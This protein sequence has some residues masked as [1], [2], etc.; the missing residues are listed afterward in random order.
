VLITRAVKDGDP[1]RRRLEELGA[2][3]LQLPTITVEPPADWSEI[4]A[5]LSRLA[6]YG[7]VVFTSRHAVD[8]VFGRLPALGLGNRLPPGAEI[9]ASGEVTAGRLHELGVAR[10]MR[11][12]V[13]SGSGVAAALRVY[14]LRGKRILYPT[15]DLARPALREDLE[16]EGAQVDQVVAYRT[17][18]PADRDEGILDA[19]KRGE[20]DVVTLAS[21]SALQNLVAMLRPDEACLRRTH[22]VCIGETTAQAV[23]EEGFEV[24]AVAR[25]P[26][27]EGMVEAICGEGTSGVLLMAYGTPGSLDDVEAYYTHIRGGRTPAPELVEELRERYRLVGGSTPLYAISEATRAALEKRLNA[28][29]AGRYRVILG[30]KHWHPFIEEA[31]QQ[32]AGEGIERAVGLVLAPHYSRMSG[33]TYFE[34][35]EAAQK[36]HGTDIEVRRIESW[37]LHP[38]Y[39]K[40]VADRVRTRLA[41]FLCGSEVTVIFTAHSLP[42]KILEDDDPYPRQLRETSEA[43]AAMLGLERWTFAYQSAGRTSE[44]WLGP[45]LVDA[46]HALA[47]EGVRHILVATIGFV[48]DHLEILYDIDHEAQQA[49]RE[50]GITLKRTESLNANDDFIEGLAELV[51]GSG[52]G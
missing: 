25:E 34:Y 29:E 12:G 36:K 2:A 39:L 22:L 1:L 45:D 17:V 48:S 7:Y 27:A 19:L 23:R 4:D 20:I 33:E 14:D 28:P 30:M 11:S 9:V 51:R 15:S 21:P 6:S 10:V 43:L 38:P 49:A 47:G 5:A 31:V 50:H 26:S 24:A 40:A 3:V 37:H 41:E 32:M 8:A 46:V 52:Y 44:P 18:L 16:A 42:E 13:Q 35:V